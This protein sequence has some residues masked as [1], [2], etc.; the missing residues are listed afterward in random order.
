VRLK[1]DH[2]PKDDDLFYAITV[3]R[4]NSFSYYFPSPSIGICATMNDTVVT[5][6]CYRMPQSYF[7]LDIECHSC[8]STLLQN[9]IRC[10]VPGRRGSTYKARGHV[11]GINTAQRQTV[12][13]L[14]FSWHL[15]TSYQGKCQRLPKR[16]CPS[17]AGAWGTI[18]VS[19]DLV[20]G[21][22]DRSPTLVH[23]RLR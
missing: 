21:G 20:K 11:I 9:D 17:S 22:G 23:S 19:G 15:E 3:K 16:S 18:D 13:L 5:Q 4:A 2:K 7:N 1:L 12:A 6:P 8:N 14:V 10:I